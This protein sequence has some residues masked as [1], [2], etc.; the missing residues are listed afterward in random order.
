MTELL[1]AL[2]QELA[3]V[4]VAELGVR[5][6]REVGEVA[7]QAAQ[8]PDLLL[9]DL[10]R[11]VEQRAEARVVALVLPV[12]LLHGEL[13]GRQRVLDLVREPLRHLLPRA[14]ALEELDARARLLHLAEHAVERLAQLGQLVGAGHR[15]A[16]RQV[17]LG[18]EV[19]GGGRGG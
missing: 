8:R 2:A 13:D 15:D 12:A 18:D 10:E 9:D 6:P 16:D 3:E 1:G 19:D 5:Q 17:P 11:R 7:D 14:D 4:R